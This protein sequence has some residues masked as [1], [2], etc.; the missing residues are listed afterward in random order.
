MRVSAAYLSVILIWSTT[1]LGILWSSETVNPTF[2]VLMRMLIA[3]V[4]GSAV[5]RLW[6]IELPITKDAMRLYGFS[7]I[8]VFGGMLFSYLSASYISSGLMSLIFGLAPILAG[9]MAQRIISEP[10]FNGIKKFALTI[11]LLGL[12]IVC[13]DSVLLSTASYIGILYVFFAVFFFSLSSVL[14]KSVKL[15]IN[16]IATTVGSLL[17]ST[18]LFFLVWLVFDGTLP[19]QQWQERSLWAILYLGVIG[20]L[21]GFLAYFYILQKL[22][23]STVAL[24][25]MLTPILA[26][27]IGAELNQEVITENLIIG[28]LCVVSGLSLFQWGGKIKL[29]SL[30]VVAKSNEES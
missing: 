2:A 4:L 7:G 27:G 25:T 23:A 15:T 22:N 16:P 8:G 29:K 5:L 20:S 30:F 3:L 17:V 14:V 21:F 28:A 6:R 9:L 13:Y 1:P 26:M 19:Y 10:K 24:I 11:A 12:V 18:P